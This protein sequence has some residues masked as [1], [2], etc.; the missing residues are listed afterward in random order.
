MRTKRL[1]FIRLGVFLLIFP[2]CS[3]S[4]GTKSGSLSDYTSTKRYSKYNAS[5]KN[6]TGNSGKVALG[7]SGL[8]DRYL[9]YEVLDYKRY[10]F[11]YETGYALDYNSV[12]IYPGAL[13]EYTLNISTSYFSEY[14]YTYSQSVTCQVSNVFAATF[15]LFNMAEITQGLEI[16]TGLTSSGSKTY[17]FGTQA[18]FNESF[19]FDLEKI[20]TGYVFTPVIICEAEIFT[21]KYHAYGQWWWGDILTSNP[22]EHSDNQKLVV[23]N[24]STLFLTAGIK[25]LNSNSKEPEYY[26][27][28]G[29]I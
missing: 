19:V 7:K 28:S 6:P 26:L 10:Y 16:S 14:S 29:L 1:N 20:P 23:Y 22:D 15:N 11:S 27:S 13:K 4:S 21:L 18:T 17:G 3:F 24:P 5:G 12:F 25:K 9:V 8:I 2:L